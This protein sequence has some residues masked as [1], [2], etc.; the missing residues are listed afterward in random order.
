MIKVFLQWSLE[1]GTDEFVCIDLSF[2][3]SDE[4]NEHGFK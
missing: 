2:V 3:Y 1:K 4:K